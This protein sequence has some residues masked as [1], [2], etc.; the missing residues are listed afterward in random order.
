MGGLG[1][2]YSKDGIACM[3]FPGAGGE[4]PI[5]MLENSL[6]ITILRKRLT[7]DSGGPG[8]F[9][10]GSGQELAIRSES[11]APLRMM[12]QNMKVQTPAA[13]MV[14]GKPGS[15]GRNALNG[16]ELPGKVAVTLKKGDV[17]EIAIAGGGGMFPPEQ[18]SVELL[19]ADIDQLAVTIEGAKR[20]YAVSLETNKTDDK[21]CETV[22]RH[23]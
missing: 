14:G 9:R 12:L 13:G 6:P 21:D 4:T 2:R 20:D 11:N 16:K 10:G 3:G 8:R 22:V 19:N 18:R 15:L 23:A 7:P 5:E 17:V 1:A